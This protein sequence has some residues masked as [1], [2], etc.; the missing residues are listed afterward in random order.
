LIRCLSQYLDKLIGNISPML[1]FPTPPLIEF[2]P[3]LDKCSVCGGALKVQK[4][5]P[6]IVTTLHIGRFYAREVILVCS[7]CGCKHRC[8]QL[9][10]LVPPG[11]NFGYDVLVY[12][13]KALYIRHRSEEEVVAE[14]AERN[15]QISPRGASS[16]GNK[17]IVYLAIAHDRCSDDITE[18]M[19][20]RGGGYICHLD[21][22]CEGRDPILMS[23]LDSISQIVLGNIKLPAE[24][25]KH[26]VPFL[27]RM[28]KNYGIPIAL[29]HDMGKGILK[30]VTKVFPGAPDFICHF[31]FL[32]DIGKDFLGDQYDIIRKRLSKHQIS[33]KLRYRAK[34]L[35]RNIDRSPELIDLLETGIGDNPL[36]RSSLKSLADLNGYT[37]I[38]WTLEGKSEGNGYGFP[39]DRPHLTFARRISQLHSYVDTLKNV[40]LSREYKNNKPYFKIERDLQKIIKDKVLWNAV[41]ELE[42]R[43]LVFERLR[44][45]MRI[46]NPSGRRGLN[47]EGNKTNIKTIE[48]R[49]KKFR[50]WLTTRKNYSQ[51][52]DAQKMIAQI[53]KYWEKL[54]ADPITVQTASGPIQIQPQRTNNILEQFFRNLKRSNRRKTG[55]K[56]SSRMLRTMLA[57]TPLVNNLQNPEYMK[58]LLKNKTSLEELFAEIEIDTLRDELR[59]AQLSP[60]KVPI[61]IKRLI[62]MPDYPEKLLNMVEKAAA[63]S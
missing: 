41:E 57:E 45:A 28:K 9:C 1:L 50:V 23:S 52:H 53:D 33:S 21:A 5:R 44:K 18:A 34:Q 35:K 40:Q 12:V 19:R 15:I 39:F 13:G 10:N 29:V 17:F 26:I 27:Q 24:D 11:A 61:K 8:E 37:L 48:Y 59:K 4:T 49:V 2:R 32:R 36:S 51:N 47:D 25:E 56:S 42:K 58:I 14:L 55:N 30:A 22:T 6:R 20:L 46:A 38:R 54:F 7:K 31:H 3:S 63:S 16:L 43:I 60:E 62:A